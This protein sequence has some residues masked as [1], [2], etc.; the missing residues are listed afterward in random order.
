MADGDV[1]SAVQTQPIPAKSIQIKTD[2]PRPYVCA[3][4]T[5]SFARLE[6]LKRHERSH[7]K[8]KPFQCPVCE[9]S[10]AR[11]DL[12]LRH[13]QKLHAA[14]SPPKNESIGDA[15]SAKRRASSAAVSAR[16]V[17]AANSPAA[18]AGGPARTARSRMVA[19]MGYPNNG[20]MNNSY[21]NTG[22]IPPADAQKKPQQQP[23]PRN[24]GAGQPASSSY[25]TGWLPLNPL[26]HELDSF[27][28]MA[29]SYRHLTTRESR[30]NSFNAS[31]VTSYVRRKDVDQYMATHTPM[32]GPQEVSFST[33]Q[34]YAFE[35]EGL[36]MPE[37]LDLETP[38]SGSDASVCVNPQQLLSGTGAPG[39]LAGTPGSVSGATPASASGSVPTPGSFPSM[40][41]ARQGDFQW[42]PEYNSPQV[43]DSM[44]YATPMMSVPATNNSFDSPMAFPA[45]QNSGPAA[46]RSFARDPLVPGMMERPPEPTN[47][48]QEFFDKF[49]T[50]GDE[51]DTSEKQDPPA[52]PV[53]D[54]SEFTTADFGDGG[55][56]AEVKR[57][58]ERQLDLNPTRYFEELS[59]EPTWSRR[60]SAP[61]TIPPGQYNTV[62]NG[63]PG[64]R[65]NGP[66]PN[67]R[68]EHNGSHTHL[69]H[70]SVHQ[71]PPGP[72][73]DHFSPLGPAEPGAPGAVAQAVPP[74]G[75]MLPSSDQV[76]RYVRAY[77]KFFNPHLHFIHSST[78]LSSQNMALVMVMAAI[79]ALYLGDEQASLRIYD[80]GRDCT[81]MYS[82]INGD[83]TVCGTASG[84]ETPAVPLWLVQASALSVVYGLFHKTRDDNEMAIHQGQRLGK[85][86]RRAGLHMPLQPPA[87]IYDAQTPVQEKW[88]HFLRSQKRIRTMYAVHAITTMMTTMY[89]LPPF[90]SNQDLQCG[91]PCDEALWNAQN[92]DDWWQ[93]VVQR[94]LQTRFLGGSNF[95]HCFAVLLSEQP[96]MEHVSQTLLLTLMYSIHLEI[97]QRRAKHSLMRHSEQMF[98]GENFSWTPDV[99]SHLHQQHQQDPMQQVYFSD[100]V[101]RAWESTW[102]RSPLASLDP[103]SKHGPIMSECVPLASLAYIRIHV[104]LIPVKERFWAR[105]FVGMNQELDTLRTTAFLGLLA[106]A[107]YAVDT[108]SLA[109]KYTLGGTQLFVHTIM[110]MVDCAFVLSETLYEISHHPHP[111]GDQEQ[112]IVT[113]ANKVFSR[114][115]DDPTEPL[116]VMALRGISRVLGR[117][118]VWPYVD[119]IQ[120]ALESRIANLK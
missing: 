29:P 47:N 28:N 119:V 11:R 102:S 92:A 59:S 61:V 36:A 37:P 5:R 91:S 113:R 68:K 53:L 21:V 56:S 97:A 103:N 46:T 20:E 94:E 82:D 116:C 101:V 78:K 17:A 74:S 88:A 77:H 73:T 118:K 8:E 105:D 81:R 51:N 26:E 71:P 98:E 63:G 34:A 83:I 111:L 58:L 40:R 114:L 90:A 44:S 32:G 57:K 2:K 95:G 38:F 65:I 10:F 72:P 67:A 54:F 115:V 16:N 43:A 110:C 64:P 4:C 45:Y 104:D 35:P 76:R 106:S 62:H 1:Q 60:A 66:G 31:S 42:A 86:T 41:G 15:P 109:E 120:E 33:P 93:L 30:S 108:V 24:S 75:P 55:D 18:S 85:L 48:G 6:H 84:D 99:A 89:G 25:P 70:H 27:C 50:M 9:R 7:T 19:P 112:R 22:M 52:D 39:P 87:N 14:F 69:R 80:M 23:I 96:V 79:G 49:I 12:L 13:K 117:G 100:G 107:N 3:T